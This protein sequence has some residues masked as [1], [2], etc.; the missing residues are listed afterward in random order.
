M[1]HLL[2]KVIWGGSRFFFH[3]K[4]KK[5]PTPRLHINNDRSLINHHLCK[6][7]FKLTLET[8]GSY[9]WVFT[10]HSEW[11]NVLPCCQTQWIVWSVAFKNKLK[12]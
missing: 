1:G 12:V 6:N 3:A 7:L 11:G 10:V 2:Y 5:K 8:V 4:T 9:S